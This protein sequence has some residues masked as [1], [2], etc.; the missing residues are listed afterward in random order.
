VKYTVSTA[1]GLVHTDDFKSACRVLRMELERKKKE[2][3]EAQQEKLKKEMIDWLE[4]TI[5]EV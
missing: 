1:M 2:I 4:K 3:L 5:V